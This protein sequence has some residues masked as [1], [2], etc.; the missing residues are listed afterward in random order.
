MGQRT[1]DQRFH[2]KVVVLDDGCWEWVGTLYPNGYGRFYDTGNHGVR[3][4]RWSFERE[5]GPIP[6]GLQIDHECHDPHSCPGGKSDRHRRCVNPAHMVLA[7]VAQNLARRSSVVVTQCPH[8][9]E[10]TE[11]NTYVTSAGTRQCVECTRARSRT[12]QRARRAAQ[13]GA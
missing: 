7:T 8:G 11:E 10:Y 6:E 3:A 2:D 1:Q 4:H 5:N 12:N 13:M 9:H